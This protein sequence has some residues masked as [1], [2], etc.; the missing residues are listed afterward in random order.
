MMQ[1]TTAPGGEILIS[2]D[3]AFDAFVAWQIR[4]RLGSLPAGANVVLDFSAVEEFFDLGVAVMAHG[5]AVNDG[6]RVELR[7]LHEHQHR[8]FRY[9]GIEVDGARSLRNSFAP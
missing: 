8:L 1:E 5:L 9:F 7:G 6:A 3:G 2:L 4:G